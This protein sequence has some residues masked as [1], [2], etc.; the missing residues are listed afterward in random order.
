MASVGR[1]P[2]SRAVRSGV[3]AELLSGSGP[4]IRSRFT[5][6]L[7]GPAIELSGGC[8]AH[9]VGRQFTAAQRRSD[10]SRESWHCILVCSRHMAPW[11][12]PGHRRAACILVRLADGA[13]AAGPKEPPALRFGG[14][15]GE[16]VVERRPV[17][18]SRW[19]WLVGRGAA[20]PNERMQLTWLLGAPIRAGLGSR[21]RLRAGRPRL[22]RHAA[23]ASR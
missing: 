11:A 22:T 10:R 14:V 3:R 8:A 20:K 12:A 4:A 1:S 2:A 5:R 7:S 17:Y 13:A 18:Q 9:R 15:S 21:P 19:F 23:D 16:C 6:L